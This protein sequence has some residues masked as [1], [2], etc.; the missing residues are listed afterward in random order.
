MESQPRPVRVQSYSWRQIGDSKLPA[1]TLERAKQFTALVIEAAS[2]TVPRTKPGKNTRCCITPELR[3][4]ISKRNRLRRNLHQNKNEWLEIC[5]NVRDKVAAARK[6]QWVE[7]IEEVEYGTDLRKMW[8]VLHFLGD[9]TTPSQSNEALKLGDKTI[10]SSLK[11]VDAFMQHYE[12]RKRTSRRLKSAMS[13]GDASAQ[14]FTKLELEKAI[15]SMRSRGAAGSD[16]IT[17]AFIKAFIQNAKCALLAL[18]NDS[19]NHAAVPQGWRN[20]TIIPLLKAGKDLASVASYRPIS[21][22]SCLAKSW[23]LWS[24]LGSC[25]WSK[26][27]E[28]LATTNVVDEGRDVAKTSSSDLRKPL[29]TP[30]NPE[31]LAKWLWRFSITARHSTVFGDKS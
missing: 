6:N 20:A 17:P 5:R 15:A 3:Q 14:D 26:I 18:Y 9:S 28:S 10:S 24:P 12:E 27:E 31:I 8:S 16:E 19:W 25:T 22:T 29:S 1:D 23:N 30:S 11:K 2:A 4:L 21:L 13:A 7:F